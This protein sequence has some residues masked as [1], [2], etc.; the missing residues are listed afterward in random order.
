ML[1]G[2][3]VIIGVHFKNLGNISGK[4]FSKSIS[5]QIVQPSIK[6]W[7]KAQ[8]KA[9]KA[10]AR[11]GEAVRKKQPACGPMLALAKCVKKL[12]RASTQDTHSAKHSMPCG[13]QL[14]NI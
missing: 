11:K 6:I 12:E 8:A 2:D 13:D 1:L 4:P 10:A 7:S 5:Y 3:S 9:T 14:E